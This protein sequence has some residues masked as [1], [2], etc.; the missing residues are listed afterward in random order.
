LP[1]QIETLRT[2][3]AKLEAVLADPKVF[4]EKRELAE[5]SSKALETTISAL[6]VA[7]EK[8]LELEI[9]REEIEG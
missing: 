1:G 6:A 7:E 4:T 5:K 3:K 9:L 2:Q 8:W